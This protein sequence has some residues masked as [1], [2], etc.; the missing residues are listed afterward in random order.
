MKIRVQYLLSLFIVLSVFSFTAKAQQV[1]DAQIK[2][3]TTPITNSLSYITRLQPVS[4]EY[5]RG[6]YKQL[7][8]PV[9]TQFGFIAGDAKQVVPSVIT[10][11]NN[12]YN[13]GKNNP[14]TITTAEVDMQKLVPLL[15]GAIKEQQAVIEKLKQEVQK[16]KEAR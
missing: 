4:Y 16:L 9:G 12:W 14:R 5:N 10:T 15:V 8:L 6:D 13:A 3:N 11:H 2:T 7:N 1:S